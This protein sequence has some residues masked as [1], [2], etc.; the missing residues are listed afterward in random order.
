MKDTAA[1]IRRGREAMNKAITESADVKRAMYRNDIGWVDFV[2]GTEDKA[3]EKG[4]TKGAM[5]ISHIIEARMRK[6]GM[7]RDDV[8]KM[9][10]QDMVETIARGS[11]HKHVVSPNGK[12]ER[13]QL[14][15]NGYEANLIK[16]AGNNAW[17][18]T[19]YE[20]Y[21]SGADGVGFDTSAATHN[22]PTPARSVAGAPD[23]AT[24][25]HASPEQIKQTRQAV[26]QAVGKHNMRHIEIVAREEVARPDN[27]ED[28]RD[29][30]GWYDPNAA[31]HPDC[32][33]PA[34][35]AHGAICGLA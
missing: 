28:L 18:L 30:Q 27:A 20:L 23:T 3:D 31:H 19:G 5:G 4:R 1:N 7:S 2:W 15:H 17:L 12:S 16:N 25:V 32:R 34:Q 35:S 9:L 8:V 14:R 21:Q 10:T 29:A 6:D 22:R 11:V 33:S 24:T 13:L 26:E